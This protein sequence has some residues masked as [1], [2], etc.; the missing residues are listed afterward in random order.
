MK[1]P[2]IMVA[3][4]SLAVLSAGQVQAASVLLDNFE[5]YAWGTQ[6][7]NPSIWSAANLGWVWDGSIQGGSTPYTR[8]NINYSSF[9]PTGQALF[10]QSGSSGTG[11]PRYASTVA[12]D[13][14]LGG[15]ISFNLSLGAV[16]S[17]SYYDGPFESQDSN[18]NVRLQYSTNNGASWNLLNQFAINEAGY[19]M[20]NRWS[21]YEYVLDANHA[22]ATT[23]TMFR[24]HQAQ[25]SGSYYD[26]WAID[27]FKVVP[28]PEPIS[29]VMLGC[30]GVGMAGARKLRRK[31]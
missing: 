29:V 1:N 11:S 15:T 16:G 9:F 30:L 31:R 13:M 2:L 4:I 26:T 8:D 28:V 5:S 19:T 22:S 3:M 27:N 7:L 18:E 20:T 17:G 6:T 23:N 21:L 14:S 25:H 12:V 24:L 10:F